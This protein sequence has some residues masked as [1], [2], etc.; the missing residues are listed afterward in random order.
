MSN[1]SEYFYR[2]GMTNEM[3]KSIEDYRAS[4]RDE[5]TGKTPSFGEAMR[6]LI[7]RGLA[8]R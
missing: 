7:E 4:N 6:A 8:A 5:E 1:K 2:F 3:R